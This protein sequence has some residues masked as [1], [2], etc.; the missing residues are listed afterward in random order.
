MAAGDAERQR[1]ERNLHDG[2]QQ[3][4]LSLSLALRIAKQRAALTADQPLLATLGE[5]TDDLNLAL[6][7]LRELARGIHPAVLER[8]GLGAAIQSLAERSA[9]PVQI[10]DYPTHRYP[11]TIEATAYF[12]ISEALANVA[13]HSAATHVTIS[14]V[15]SSDAL[16]IEVC[17]DGAGGADSSKGSGLTGLLDRVATLGGRLV[18][19]SPEG[20]GTRVIADIPCQQLAL[21]T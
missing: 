4:L 5:A 3:R 14:V 20:A 18:V 6:S 1:V 12:V 7:E 13:K 15:G 10:L 21:D 19:N 9:V 16:R 11:P 17:D 2:A 8:S